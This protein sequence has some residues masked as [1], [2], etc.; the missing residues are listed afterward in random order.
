M[1]DNGRITRRT[2]LALS[3]AGAAALATGGLPDIA[4]AA[5]PALPL[6]K[7]VE[8]RDGE[9]IVL[10][11]RPGSHSFDGVRPAA[12]AGI[13]ADYLAP[14]VRVR[15]G[16]TIRFKVENR[17]KEETTLHWHGLMVPSAVDGGPHNTI[18]PGDIWAPEIAI[19][20]PAATTWFH[21]HPHGR[22]ARQVYQGLT[23]MMI[24]TDGGD[25]DRG[26]PNAYGVDDLPIILQDKRFTANGAI[27]YRPNMMDL[28]HGFRGNQLLVNGMIAPEAAVPA[29]LVRLRLL[30]AANARNFSLRFG[31][32]RPFFVIAGDGG[33]I[34]DP[35]EL[36]ALIVAP[37]ERYEILV[38]F[39]DGRAVE[40]LNG[41]DPDTAGMM[42]IP[43]PGRSDV[44]IR[45]RPS[46]APQVSYRLPQGLDA[47]AEPDV[48]TAVS[49][50]TFTLDS[51]SM[52]MMGGKHGPT[53]N[54]RSFDMGRIDVTAKR[55]TS[56]IWEIVARD[57]PHPFH[58]H[59]ARFRVLGNGG[60]KTEPAAVGWKD[61]V[62]VEDRA[63]LLIV[64]DQPA[65]L[66][67]PFMYHC[68]ILEHED[69]GMMG[70]VAII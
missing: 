6:P 47:P 13:S 26:L 12:T 40:L 58:V 7:L 49:W 1:T 45:F 67:K 57:M 34:G 10:T 19:S 53:I 64:F 46:S 8:G 22:T 44:L 48:K 60:R 27:D 55:D 65:P 38:D 32:G 41:D 15:R 17:L 61:V 56:E 66:A 35:A 52:G 3:G 20:Q 18:R 59:G 28:M 69:Q 14:V 51:M 54:G 23:G 11:M 70:Q 4:W 63:E 29:G 25:A 36:R 50:R 68:H 21:P 16:D 5:A 31:D 33:Y 24:V 30:N 9:T 43:L 39:A 2:L 42:G 37:G 62:L